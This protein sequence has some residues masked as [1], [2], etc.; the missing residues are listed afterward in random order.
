MTRAAPPLPP[1]D[2]DTCAGMLYSAELVEQVNRDALHSGA[3]WWF[4][5]A[6]ALIAI[7]GAASAASCPWG[8][9]A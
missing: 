3:P 2:P 1:E 7:I 6:A 9:A 5:E 8:F 4:W